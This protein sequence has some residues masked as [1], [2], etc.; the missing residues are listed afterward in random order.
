MAF[1]EMKPFGRILSV[2]NHMVQ[3]Y[4]FERDP[5]EADDLASEG[6]NIFELNTEEYGWL[7]QKVFGESLSGTNLYTEK[8]LRDSFLKPVEM[9]QEQKGV[10]ESLK[11]NDEDIAYM[12][13]GLFANIKT[14]DLMRAWLNPKEVIKVVE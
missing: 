4:L 10:F 8:Q 2:G 3:P 14:D 13:S 1:D 7:S 11:R 5:V 9:T 12:R 6:V